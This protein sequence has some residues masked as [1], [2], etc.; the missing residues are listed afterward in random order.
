M[1]KGKNNWVKNCL[2]ALAVAALSF[3]LWNIIFILIWLIQTV[4]DYVTGFI[5]TD[6]MSLANWYPLFR[7]ILSTLLIAGASL[8]IFQSKS[9]QF[10]KAAFLTIPT[11]ATITIAGILLYEYPSLGVTAGGIITALILYYLYK[12][13]SPWLYYFAVLFSAA[14]ML[15]VAIFRIDI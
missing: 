4:I 6:I 9:P 13:T 3:A 7:M 8:L 5:V 10:I 14:I 12:K 2:L 1:K 15:L 11:I